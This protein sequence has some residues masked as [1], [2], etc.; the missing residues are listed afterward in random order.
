MGRIVGN[1][2]VSDEELTKAVIALLDRSAKEFNEST[3]E[4]DGDLVLFWDPRAVAANNDFFM[5][6]EKD[7]Q[8]VWYGYTRDDGEVEIKDIFQSVRAQV[9]KML[10]ARLGQLD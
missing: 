6:F 1:A 5:H 4:V 7:Q 2:L 9:I 3:I 10:L 8:G